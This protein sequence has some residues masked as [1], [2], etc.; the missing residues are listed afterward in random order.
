MI[1][2]ADTSGLAFAAVALSTASLA[3]AVRRGEI[4]VGEM[5]AIIADAHALVHDQAGFVVDT[6]A[7]QAADDFLSAAEALADPTALR[8]PDETW[9]RR[10][11]LRSTGRKLP[12]TEQTELP[13]RRRQRC[14]PS[15]CGPRSD[16]ERS[17]TIN[18]TT[19]KCQFALMAIPGAFSPG[20]LAAAH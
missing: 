18:S 14:W 13:P 4:S 12:G 11:S 2:P 15:A 7:A 6:K 8:R 10:H 19:A 20:R 17:H 9:S 5:R 3:A 1:D 16:Q